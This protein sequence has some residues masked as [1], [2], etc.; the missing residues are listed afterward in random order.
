MLFF[1]VIWEFLQNEEYRDLLI[2]TVV[3]LIFGTVVFHYVEGWEWIDSLYFC[4]VTLTTIG[5]GDLYPTTVGG[6]I[7]NMFYIIL[8]LGLIL[9]FIRTIYTHY[10]NVRDKHKHH[11][12]EQKNP[13]RNH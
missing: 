11:H 1:R 10:S 3:V 5:Y 6:K 7:F 4:V 13:L 9:G 2:S 12:H 8:G